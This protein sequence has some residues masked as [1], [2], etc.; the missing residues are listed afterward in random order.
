M[1]VLRKLDKF[2]PR[3]AR[4]PLLTV[5]IFN[6][7]V[8]YSPKFLVTADRLHYLRSAFDDSLPRVPF[9]IFIY[10]LAFLQWIF[11]YIIIARDSPERQDHHPRVLP[12]LS[13][14][15]SP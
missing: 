2:I 15:A 12:A 7:I 6:F 8:Y 10:V 11:G 13:Y 3:Y 1:R 4:L 5:L 14:G 9:F